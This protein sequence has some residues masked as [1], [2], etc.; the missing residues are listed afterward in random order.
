MWMLLLLL[1]GSPTVENIDFSLSGNF[2]ENLILLISSQ[3]SLMSLFSYTNLFLM[4]IVLFCY[5]CFWTHFFL[6]THIFFHW[7]EFEKISFCHFPRILMNEIVFAKKNKQTKKF[8]E[9]SIRLVNSQEW[10]S[11]FVSMKKEKKRIQQCLKFTK[12]VMKLKLIFSSW[13]IMNKKV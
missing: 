11:N 8:S 4:F 7:W 6:Q 12:L 1:H 10:Y 5:T 9:F 13:R 2:N 3:T